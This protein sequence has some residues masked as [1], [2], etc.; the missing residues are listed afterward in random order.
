MWRNLVLINHAEKI[1]HLQFW[2]I[3]RKH[4]RVIH[5]DGRHCELGGRV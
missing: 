2:G 1:K 4:Q 3:V 5:A